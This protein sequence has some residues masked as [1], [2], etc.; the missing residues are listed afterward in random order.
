MPEY[1]MKGYHV[2][3]NGLFLFRCSYEKRHVIHEVL[4]DFTDKV[5]IYGC[6]AFIFY[7]YAKDFV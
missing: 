6:D 2:Y 5:A 1:N 4:K 7:G 3:H